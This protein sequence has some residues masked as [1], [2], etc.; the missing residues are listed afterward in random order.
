MIKSK[1]SI[2]HFFD[3]VFD[4]KEENKKIAEFD[5]YKEFKEIFY[6]IDNSNI[7]N[8]DILYEIKDI[9]RAILRIDCEDKA[10]EIRDKCEELL[11]AANKDGNVLKL[12]SKVYE[13]AI[14]IEDN[15]NLYISK[16]NNKEEFRDFI[17]DKK[18]SINFEKEKNKYKREIYK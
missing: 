18:N 16:T 17:S 6:N 1:V 3:V 2:E 5:F 15:I 10:K 4:K 9:Y 11:E 12:I 13:A 7:S 8:I 14:D